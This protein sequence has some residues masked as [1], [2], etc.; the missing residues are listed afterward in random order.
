MKKVLA[1]LLALCCVLGCAACGG[2]GNG[3]NKENDAEKYNSM[4]MDELYE[5]AKAEGG[6]IEVYATTADAN[7]AAKK[8]AKKYP[9]IAVEYISC[10]TNTVGDKIE[11]EAESNNV[12][13]DVL[14]VKD[15]SGEVF[16]ELVGY[17]YL[18]IFKPESI[19]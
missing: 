14:M 4:S 13:A 3:G 6:T 5:L 17:D 18:T 2:G 1:I 11:M 19:F 12:N 7:T 16:H 15:N 9:D 10:D 8:F